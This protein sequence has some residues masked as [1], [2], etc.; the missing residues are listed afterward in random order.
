MPAPA[1]GILRFFPSA[2]HQAIPVQNTEANMTDYPAKTFDVYDV[3][4]A[5]V[6]NAQPPFD[7]A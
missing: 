5:V 6:K 3:E 4:R 2:R 7:A 1:V